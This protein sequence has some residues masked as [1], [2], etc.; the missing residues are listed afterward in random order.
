MPPNP[1]WKVGRRRALRKQLRTRVKMRRCFALR[2]ISEGVVEWECK[3]GHVFKH[4]SKRW[5]QSVDS[6]Y[7]RLSKEY[8]TKGGGGCAVMCPHCLKAEY[9][10]I[11]EE[12]NW[13]K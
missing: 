13:S 2:Y 8:W 11:D 4:R 12:L 5:S 7:R 6:M 1:P 9:V 10:K 3:L